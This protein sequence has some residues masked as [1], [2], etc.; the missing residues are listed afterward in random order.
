MSD[1]DKTLNRVIVGILED[2]TNVKF[3]DK[4]KTELYNMPPQRFTY[5][6]N[7]VLMGRTPIKPLLIF[8]DIIFGNEMT[9]K[10]VYYNMLKNFNIADKMKNIETLCPENKELSWMTTIALIVKSH[11]LQALKP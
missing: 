1:H 9:A 7:Q 2:F 5:Y 4:I 11:N 6:L 10:E 3:D 8:N